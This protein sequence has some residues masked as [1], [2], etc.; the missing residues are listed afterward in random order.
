[1]ILFPKKG[2]GKL[3]KAEKE[4]QKRLRKTM[5]ASTQ[6]AIWY[7]SL[8]ENG[9]MH[10]T[11]K[12]WSRTYRLG[13]VAY[14]AAG[15]EDKL[16]V[17]DTYAEALNSLDSSSSYQLLVIN[18]RLSEETVNKILF[19]P[20]GD[21]FDDYR[22]E[23]NDMI[24]S[25]FAMD[26]RNFTVEKYVTISTQAGERDQA[27]RLL[28]DIGLSLDGQM[29]DI[30][31]GLYA[32]DGQERLSI[33]SHIL[34]ETGYFPY[35]YKDIALSGLRSKDF[36]APNRLAFQ[37]DRF[38]IDDKLG[39]VMYVRNYPTW[40]TDKLIKYLTDI[41]IELAISVHA[42]PYEMADFEQKLKT[43]QGTVKMSMVKNIKTG[44]ADGMTEELSVSGRDAE[45]NQ[46]TKRWQEEISDNDQKA[47]SG[48]IAV[49]FAAADLDQLKLYT[50]K[51]KAEGR[52]VG[53]DFEDCYYHQEAGLNTILPIG[54]PY[55]DVQKRF[56]R[57]MTTL[58]VATQIPFTNLD[59]Q[60]N[61]PKALYYGQNQLSNNII[62]IDR[63]ADLNT[64]NGVVLGSSGSGKSTTVKSMEVIPTYLRYPEDR[65]IIVDP[66]DEYSD[67]GREFK[68]QLVD[69]FIGSK[70]HINLLDLPDISQLNEEDS[71][72]IGDKANLLM[73]L[74]ETILDEVTDEEFT[75]I[76][77][78]TRLTYDLYDEPTLREWHDVLEKQ[79]E[80]VAKS[81]ALKS[82]IYAKGSQ[83]IFAY[84]T[85]VNLN[86]RFV[87]FNLKKLTG[88]LK[89]FALM[90][91]QD[92]I[93]NQ[94]VASQGVLTTRIYFDEVQLLFKSKIQAVFFTE[95]Y[96]RIRKYGA[97]PTAIT[98][99]IE[100][101]VAWEEGRKLLSNS[102]FMILLKHKP[103]DLA[104][105]QTVLSLSP[106][107]TKYIARPKGK[108]TG[109]IVAGQTIV[110]FENPIPK[111]TKLY[112][113]VATDA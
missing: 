110:P 84:K 25:R 1:M 15:E 79:P 52:R 64:G 17:I 26:S 11:G 14:S 56:M 45:I 9:L 73:G 30:D 13:D 49:Y 50:E 103:Q 60:S 90:V 34:R 39:K 100:T 33:F 5:K 70:T 83:D 82:E 47:F 91:I 38:K 53:V 72:P 85:N 87:V 51:I 40:L 102:E 22:H 4:R 48:V 42:K 63:K 54:M 78:V 109:L 80:V 94:V 65:I 29:K 7:T 74:F 106:T 44:F 112:H 12:E 113:L 31:V 8:F 20:T 24:S 21:G 36:I 69:I 57:D 16:L 97:I 58:N 105:L 76:D 28:H 23:Y 41:G 99:N 18:R 66:E 71:D 108:G 86:D 92:Y 35:T 55:L 6:N 104:A 98:Q 77:R 27:E 43:I 75:I 81:L 59:L 10:V 37:E 96:S 93:W 89:P 67:I 101:L 3:T 88:K 19:E 95:L 32:L 111:Q 61:A 2:S 107:L 46:A 68:A 62:T